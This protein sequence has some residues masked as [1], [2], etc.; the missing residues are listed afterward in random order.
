MGVWIETHELRV[1][2]HKE[3]VAPFV[4]VWIETPPA[5]DTCQSTCFA[6]TYS[7]RNEDVLFARVY[8]QEKRFFTITTITNLH[9]LLI[10]R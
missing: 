1:S 2:R 9:K 3:H 10:N 5:T 8:T 6:D 7:D 4:G